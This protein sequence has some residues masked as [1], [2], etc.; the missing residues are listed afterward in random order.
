MATSTYRESG[1]PLRRATSFTFAV[2]VQLLLLWLLF[3]LGTRTPKQPDEPPLS[4]FALDAERPAARAAAKATTARRAPTRSASSSA[5]A[6]TPPPV[7]TPPVPSEKAVW[8][9]MLSDS[10]D[11]ARAP[12]G[13]R[14]AE[15]GHGDADARGDSAVAYG[16]GAGPGGQRLYD[17]DWQREPSSSEIS[18]YLKT[19]PPPDS[20]A[21][22]ACKTAEDYRVEDCRVLGESPIGSGLGRS[23]REAAWQFRILPPRLGGKKLLGAWVRI[24]ISWT[25]NG[26]QLR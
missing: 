12:K 21:L 3:H 15:E 13:D 8:P 6:S 24:R 26:A 17:A 25:Q 20:W 5:A 7:R 18:G 11:L 19:A 4:T 16:P 22:I 14:S 23:M 2:G 10:F 1:S 9:T